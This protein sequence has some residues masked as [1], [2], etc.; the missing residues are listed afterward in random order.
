MARMKPFA[1]P[2]KA[3]FAITI[4]AAMLV[5]ACALREPYNHDERAVDSVSLAPALAQGLE[6]APFCLHLRYDNAFFAV[7]SESRTEA[8]ITEGSCGQAGAK[9][10]VETLRISWRHDFYDHQ[11]TRQCLDTDRCLN[12]DQHVVEGRNIRCAS[13]QARQ[14]NQTAFVTTDQAVCH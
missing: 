10:Q 5:S 8:W 14:G 1:P 3:A 13:A 9:R 6:T 2:A 7:A 12:N 11:L 4:V